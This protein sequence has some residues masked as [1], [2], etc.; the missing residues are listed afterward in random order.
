MTTLREVLTNP[1]VSGL[2]RVSA[3]TPVAA[4]RRRIERTGVRPG[5][6]DGDT[7]TDK[8]A[9][10]RA[11]AAGLAFP[12]YFG[13]N[14]DALADCLADL[15]WLPAPG[16]AIVYDNP[17]PLIRHAPADWAVAQEV[18]LD[19]AAYWRNTGKPFAVLLRRT[20]SL[21]RTIPRLDL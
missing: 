9:L 2:Y 7:I 19:A 6:I 17:T 18:F 5:L 10:L 12:P 8:P 3:R 20:G 16:Y 21:A 13:Q 15:S 14:W 4:L 11:C 1:A